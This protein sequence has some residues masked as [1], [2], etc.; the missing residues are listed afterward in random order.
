MEKS[1]TLTLF[2]L[3]VL[4]ISGQA[5]D[6]ESLWIARGVQ[7]I[8]T[9]ELLKTTYEKN[10]NEENRYKMIIEQAF[11]NLAK[12]P[13]QFIIKEAVSFQYILSHDFGEDGTLEIA[14]AEWDEQWPRPGTAFVK[15]KKV[16]KGY[17][18]SIASNGDIDIYFDNGKKYY[19]V[20]IFPF[21]NGLEAR[22]H[23]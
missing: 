1:L 17:S 18:A 19:R 23:L 8:K 14:Y 15:I 12:N 3:F 4:A 16:P 13:K 22:S 9:L 6:R 10:P 5:Q 2:F 7:A 11:A 21:H 20:L